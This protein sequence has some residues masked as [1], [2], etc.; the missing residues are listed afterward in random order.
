MPDQG[1]R[2]RAREACEAVL[3]SGMLGEMTF[4]TGVSHHIAQ[5]SQARLEVEGSLHSHLSV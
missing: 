1:T 4:I 5:S 2:G 3:V